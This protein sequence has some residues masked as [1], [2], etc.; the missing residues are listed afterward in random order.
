MQA[1]SCDPLPL[2][3]PCPHVRLL[4]AKQ[5]LVSTQQ[6]GRTQH[7]SA[8]CMAKVATLEDVPKPLLA[9]IVCRAFQ[10]A[11]AALSARLTLSLVCRHG[12]RLLHI[13]LL[14]SLARS[15]RCWALRVV[16]SS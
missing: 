14:L 1:V 10:D 5:G 4:A 2:P 7:A 6:Q 8:V 3:D 15:P 12:G 16:R 13:A 11:G 9:A